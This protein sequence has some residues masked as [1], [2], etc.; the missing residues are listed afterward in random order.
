MPTSREFRCA[1]C[2]QH[3]EH[4]LPDDA[5]TESERGIVFHQMMKC[6]ICGELTKVKPVVLWISGQ[7]GEG[8]STLS[9]WV[10][11]LAESERYTTDSFV[12]SLPKRWPG[13]PI[14]EAA[15]EFTPDRIGVFLDRMVKNGKGPEIA[16]LLCD[17]ENGFSPDAS[18]G[19][20]SI[21]EGYMPLAIQKQVMQSLE[22]SGFRVW[23][24]ASRQQFEDVLKIPENWR[25]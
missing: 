21:I 25:P 12:C 8:K 10:R 20:I 22:C 13:N 17:P 16:E 6:Q 14:A 15:S 1:A 23:V 18:A 4:R 2:K 9:L 5:V 3:T 24:A 19:A 7:P 11:G